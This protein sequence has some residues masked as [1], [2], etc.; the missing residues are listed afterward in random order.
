MQSFAQWLSQLLQQSES[1]VQRLLS[2]ETAVH[3]LLAWSLFESKCFRNDLKACKLSDFAEEFA[4]SNRVMLQS[5]NVPARH[6][7]DRYQDRKKLS[8]LIPKRKTPKWMV[9]ALKEL[10]ATPY[11]QLSQEEIVQLVAFVVYRFRNNMFHGAKGV[12]S[13][14]QYREQIRVCV[15]ALQVFV[16]YAETKLPTM[17]VQ[18]SV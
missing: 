16:T 15:D 3:F 8:N 4:N 10:L 5:L 11:D 12:Q 6:F 1:E 2:D 17:G 7:H 18:E 14:L 13:W 9:V